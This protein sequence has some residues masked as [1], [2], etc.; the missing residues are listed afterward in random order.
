MTARPLLDADRVGFVAR[1]G[2]WDDA[3]HAAAAQIRRVLDERGVELVR[4]VFCDQHGV[5][6]GK[7]F[8]RDAFDTVLRDGCTAPSSLLLKDTSGRSVYPVFSPGGGIGV[9]GLGGAGDV[10]LVPDPATFRVL[11]W[12]ERTGWVLCDLRFPDG[13]PVPLSTREIARR[14]LD[15]LAAR[16]FD[17][18]V[19]VELEFHVFRSD[20]PA[21]LTPGGR[22]LHEEDLDALDG[23]VQV[24]SRALTAL[25]LPLRSI[26]PEFGASQLE[27]T[28]APQHG[29]AAADAVVLARTAIRQVCRRH[30]YRATFMSRP[31]GAAVS[32]GWHLH[33]SLVETATGENAFAPDGPGEPLSALGRRYLAGLLR[34]APAAAVFTTPTV[35]GYRRYQRLSLAPDRVGW[36]VDNK[37]AMIRTVGGAGDPATRLENRSGEPA[38]NPYLYVASQVFSGLAGIDGELDP[39]PPTDAPYDDDAARR[40]PADLSEALDALRADAVLTAGLEPR[41][42][43]VDPHA[44]ARGGGAL[45]RRGLG[46]GGAGVRGAV[47]SGR[48]QALSRW[49]VRTPQ[50]TVSTTRTSATAI[51]M[52][53]VDDASWSWKIARAASTTYTNG[54]ARER[55]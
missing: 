44:Q 37:G 28:L 4:V 32:S 24:L 19:G 22:L 36:G 10:V 46:V 23:V 48:R 33:Q 34:H 27:I 9:P 43:G 3:A 38:A 45:P 41:G 55:L 6:H 5:L 40:L 49:N 15:G 12:A 1:H 7:A 53:A 50:L 16:G 11:P 51:P 26:E 17:L 52:S 39:G 29:L 47:L 25:D 2:L 21:P 8:T 13:T 30:G 35:N 54:L 18:V 42:G 14:A 31:L 20:D